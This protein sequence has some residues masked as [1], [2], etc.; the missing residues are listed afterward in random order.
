[1]WMKEK[2]W[3]LGFG[4]FKKCNFFKS[5]YFSPEFQIWGIGTSIDRIN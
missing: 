1:M 5:Q 2:N 3:D 4:G